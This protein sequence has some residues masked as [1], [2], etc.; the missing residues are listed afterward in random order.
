M[1][2]FSIVGIGTD[3]GKTLV[4]IAAVELLEAAYFKPIQAGDLTQSDTL[5]VKKW[6]S[7]NIE[8][9]DEVY[10]LSEPMAPHAAAEIDGIT[11]RLDKI[12]KPIVS[13]PLIV[14]GAGGIFVPL[15][16]KETMLDV[17]KKMN[18]PIILVSR[19]YLGSINH[20]FLTIEA[21][22]SAGLNIAG[23]VY[24]GEES[25][26]T[27]EIIDAFYKLKLLGRIS[28]PE[29]LDKAYVQ[30]SANALSSLLY[31]L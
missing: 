20:T 21:I 25:K 13:R 11:I 27:E 23:I 8:I 7:S 4:S 6:C 17:Y 24:V 26:H 2:G 5:K 30:S 9:I 12:E 22:Q 19:H 31:E 1:N 10:R 16:E 18:L 3:V 14:E 15:N 28:I 29:K